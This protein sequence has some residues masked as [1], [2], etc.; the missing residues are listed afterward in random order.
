VLLAAAARA[1]Q[2]A[3]VKLARTQLVAS[4]EDAYRFKGGMEMLGHSDVKVIDVQTGQEVRSET[5]GSNLST[6]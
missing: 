6:S 2:A 3:A 5:D 4:P 1:G